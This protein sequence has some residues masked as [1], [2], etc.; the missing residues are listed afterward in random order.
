M[1]ATATFSPDR[2]HR[3]TLWRDW[4]GLTPTG[5]GFAMIIGLN[6]STADETENDP[7]IRRC[8]GF[9]KAWGYDALC[10]TNIFAFRETDRDVMTQQS[11]PIGPDNDQV[12]IDLSAKASIVVAAWGTYGAHMG[13]GE[14]VRHLLPNLHCLRLTKYGHPEHPLYLPGS[15]KPVLWAQ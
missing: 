8:I 6:P 5:N 3:Y 15:L 12:L 2:V 4:A 1:E 10:M 13:R 14:Q 7:T 11:E 9:A